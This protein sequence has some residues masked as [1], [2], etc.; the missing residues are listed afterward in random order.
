[1]S[2]KLR[3]ITAKE[4]LRILKKHGYEIVDQHGS[5][6]HLKNARGVRLT[7]PVHSGRVIGPGLLLAILRQAGIDADVLR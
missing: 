4:L 1:M 2:P 5:H 6:M 7:V 3:R